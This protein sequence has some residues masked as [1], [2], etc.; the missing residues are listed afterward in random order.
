MNALVQEKGSG[1]VDYWWP[2]PGETQPAL[3]VSY[4]KLAKHGGESFVLGCGVYDLDQTE[5]DKLVGK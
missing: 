2:K 4:V 5:V 1:W 3:K